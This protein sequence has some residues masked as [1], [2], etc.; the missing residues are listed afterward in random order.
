MKNKRESIIEVASKT[1]GEKGYSLTTIDEITKKA[2]IGKGTFYIYFKNK[3]DL[4]YAIVEENF[5]NFL[6]EVKT[7][8][9]KID[10][11]FARLKKFIEMYLLHHEKNYFLFKILVQEKPSLK[12][13]EFIKFW[14]TFFSK[15]DFLK[16][17]ILKQIKEGTL[18]K[19]DPD[20]IMY[21]FLGILH[22]NIHRWLLSG[23]QY[24]L[25]KKTDTVYELFINGIRK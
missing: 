12:R 16:N 3:D 21:S 18:K 2:G 7:E 24:S 10:N 9:E 6:N 20:D 13:G 5:N 25:S 15:W 11:F 4:F 14:N 8:I 19:L 23:R 17:E 1:F 22:G